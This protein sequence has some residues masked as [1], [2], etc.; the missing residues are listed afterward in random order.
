MKQK[1][2]ILLLCLLSIKVLVTH[3]PLIWKLLCNADEK[4]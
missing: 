3:M 2:R 4:D 1:F